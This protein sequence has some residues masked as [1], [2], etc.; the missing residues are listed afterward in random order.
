V[1]FDGRMIAGNDPNNPYGGWWISLG[2]EVS[3][4]G[5]P[6]TPSEKTAGCIALSPQDA[7]DVYGIL[8]IGSEVKIR[9]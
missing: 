5:S 4:H 3:L 9:R 1:G 8:S 7:K 6:A 2:G